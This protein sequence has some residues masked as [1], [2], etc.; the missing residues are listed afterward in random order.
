MQVLKENEYRKIQALKTKTIPESSLFLDWLGL[1]SVQTLRKI[2]WTLKNKSRKS[3]NYQP[4]AVSVCDEVVHEEEWGK[5][6]VEE[7]EGN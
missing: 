6:D 3:Q 7:I 2:I 1:N 4:K 5:E